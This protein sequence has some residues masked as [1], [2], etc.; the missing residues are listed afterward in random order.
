MN[1]TKLKLPFV[2]VAGLVLGAF[3][4]EAVAGDGGH[5]KAAIEALQTARNQL[6][7]AD[8]DKGGHRAK[9]IKLVDETIAEVK[10]GIEFDKSR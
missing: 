4:H 8:A 7:K 6:E 1:L 9:A 3:A 5:M 10:A 2:L